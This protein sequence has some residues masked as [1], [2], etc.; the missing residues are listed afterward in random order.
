MIYNPFIKESI[1]KEWISSI[2]DR[3]ELGTSTHREFIEI[4][5]NIK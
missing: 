1:A 2:L 5:A 3:D 4:L